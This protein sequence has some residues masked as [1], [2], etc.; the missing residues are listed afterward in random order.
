[1]TT[2]HLQ[3]LACRYPRFINKCIK[4]L[5]NFIK[6]NL[7]LFCLQLLSVRRIRAGLLDKFDVIAW[8]LFD[9]DIDGD[10][11]TTVFGEVG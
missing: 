11:V 2:S 10:G 1:M 5:L 8:F 6:L 7:I 9:N 3:C 4:K